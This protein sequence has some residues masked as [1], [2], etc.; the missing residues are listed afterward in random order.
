MIKRFNGEFGYSLVEVMASIVILAIAI[1]PM[2]GMFDAGLK[3]ATT[4]GQYDQA[5]S[6]A[7]QQME[8]VKALRYSRPVGDTTSPSVVNNYAPPS[9]PCV[10]TLP[11]GFTCAMN[12]YYVDQATLQRPNPAATSGNVMEVVVTIGWDGG[13]KT[14][15]TTGLV[16]RGLN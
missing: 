6:L 5:R 1:I 2:V 12:T 3:S 16:S 13:S 15:T 9:P 11:Q 7:N 10:I 4:S 8:R 14:Y